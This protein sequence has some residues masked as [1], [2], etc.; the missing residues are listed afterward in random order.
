MG[1]GL[2]V[3]TIFLWT[4]L[5]ARISTI[6]CQ[7]FPTEFRT[8]IEMLLTWNS[9]MIS[10]DEGMYLTK[11]WIVACNGMSENIAH[12]DSTPIGHL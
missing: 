8:F 4:I 5:M 1:M 11:M 10:F 2:C 12:C 3:Q 6:P 7:S 9:M